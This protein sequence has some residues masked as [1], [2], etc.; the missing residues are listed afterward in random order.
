VVSSNTLKTGSLK[1]KRREERTALI[2]QAAYDVITE[3]GYYEASMD[4]IAARVG[5]AKGTLYLHFKS[6]E[7]LIFMLIEQETGKFV[8]LVDEIMNR[9]SSVQG[10]LEHILLESYNSIQSG[11]QFL[12]ALR[13]IGLN[14]GLIKD[15]IETQASM[16]GLVDRFTQ[17]FE[18]GKANGEFDATVPTAI[19]VSIFLGLMELYSNEQSELNQLSPEKLLESVSHLFFR[20]LLAKS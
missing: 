15:K 5:I 19:M 11:R 6:K 1:E 7:D 16:A 13:S 8:A 17:L 2:L 9:E 4:E 12:M 3:K 20:G 18:D 14:K 10:K